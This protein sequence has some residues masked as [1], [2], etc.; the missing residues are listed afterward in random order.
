MR[1]IIHAGIHK[2]GSSSIQDTFSANTPDGFAYAPW[3]IANHAGLMTLFAEPK[4]E[5][6]RPFCNAKDPLKAVA[7]AQAE[8]LPKLRE[9]C[10][11]TGP[12]HTVI[13]SA[14]R[15]FAMPL[16]VKQNLHAFF[17]ELCDE[18][19]VI[20]YIRPPASKAASSV[21]QVLKG[22]DIDVQ[23]ASRWPKY[24]RRVEALDTSFGR[25]NVELVPFRRDALKDGD[26]VADFAHRIG[27]NLNPNDIIN[28]NE[29]MSL[30]AMAFLYAQRRFGDGMAKAE[31]GWRPRNEALVAKITTLGSRKVTFSPE[32]LEKM[33]A[34]HRSDVEW[35][36]RRLGAS[37][38]E[39]P[40]PDGL[41]EVTDLI[42]I[43]LQNADL[44]RQLT[45]QD[46]GQMTTIEQ[47]AAAVDVI[48]LG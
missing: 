17:A 3:R 1:V 13:F 43:A 12:H 40:H 14:E 11:A 6:S 21:Q 23:L 16:R 2:T 44:L 31:A 9:M 35:M 46:L 18:V 20:A 38:A 7:A 36:E 39:T 34:E 25:E 33:S 8:W 30:E 5:K 41:T 19:R 15:V 10:S 32:Y 45:D 22:F 37:L 24:Q 48:R 26:V 4:P 27:A 28:S 42:E 29:S 47:V